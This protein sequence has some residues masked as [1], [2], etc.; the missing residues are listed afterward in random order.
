ML[1]AEAPVLTVPPTDAPALAA[2]IESLADDPRRRAALASAGQ[3]LWDARFTAEMLGAALRQALLP[4]LS[5][6]EP[7]ARG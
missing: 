6:R 5:A 2:A 7:R 1:G 4:L 3:A